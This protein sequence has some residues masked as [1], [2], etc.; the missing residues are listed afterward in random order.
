M[1]RLNAFKIDSQ[2]VE[3]GQWISPGDEYDDL[4]IR[5]RGYTDSYYDAQARKIRRAALPFGGD[6]AKVANSVQRDIRVECLI[7]HVVLDVK[8]LAD[9]SGAAVDFD[10]FCDLLRDP[11]YSQLVVAC[12]TA[13]GLVGRQT[14]QDKADATGNSAAPSA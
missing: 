11:D 2:A 6:V 8:G 9:E 7:K 1:A 13:A 5:C 4:M 10:R 3:G 14:A 12:M